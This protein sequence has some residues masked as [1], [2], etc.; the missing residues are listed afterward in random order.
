MLSC[1]GHDC[2]LWGPG[3]PCPD[4]GLM[5]L[6]VPVTRPERSADSGPSAAEEER[7][8]AKTEPVPRLT[9]WCSPASFSPCPIL[10]TSGCSDHW[11]LEN[12][13]DKHLQQSG[14]GITCYY[15]QKPSVHGDENTLS[16]AWS[17]VSRNSFSLFVNQCTQIFTFFFLNTVLKGVFK[18]ELLRKCSLLEV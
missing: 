3:S 18:C 10:V 14:D 16:K 7:L 2:P 8:P 1:A 12:I 5:R 17:W 11:H 15:N 4:T 9:S 6:R 13:K